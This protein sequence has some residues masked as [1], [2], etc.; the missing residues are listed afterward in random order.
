MKKHITLLL[1]IL[2]MTLGISAQPIYRFTV[3]IGIDRPTA[4]H[5]GGREAVVKKTEKMFERINKVFNNEVIGIKGIY[6]FVVD[7]DSLYIYEGSGRVEQQKP[8]PNH[9]YLVIM[10]GLRDHTDEGHGGWN[11]S[12]IQVIGHDRGHVPGKI[13]DPFDAGAT[14]GIVHEFGHARGIVDIYAEVVDAA[15]NPING[16]RF[17]AVRCIMNGCYGET[18]WS[19][20]AVNILN[21]TQDKIIDIDH[22]I[23]N[24]FPQK[25]NINLR[26]CDNKP[27]ED[28]TIKLYPVKWYSFAVQDTVYW[29][30]KTSTQG[31]YTLLGNPYGKAKAYGLRCC[32]FLVEA[33]HNGVK[34][35]GWLPLYE[36]Q[37]A[38]FDAKPTYELN[39]I[40]K[41]DMNIYTNDLSTRVNKP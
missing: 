19:R 31:V 12:T 26:D 8:H 30:G 6:N 14:D 9:D 38:F 28:A 33:E 39:L 35:Y 23:A 37:N 17:G 34:T 25:V 7:Y 3:K 32:N 27:I 4:D 11:G 29:Q 22:V 13:S 1:I 5:L 16:E 15:K 24:L 10:D 21:L 36:V 40:E 18:H 20:Y 41:R 2:I